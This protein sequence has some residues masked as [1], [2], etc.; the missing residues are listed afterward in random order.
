[1]WKLWIWMCTNRDIIVELTRNR[2]IHT[3]NENRRK[4]LKSNEQQQ[5]QQKTST[6]ISENNSLL[7][8]HL[9]IRNAE[10]RHMVEAVYVSFIWNHPS[11]GNDY[12]SCGTHNQL[13]IINCERVSLSLVCVCVFLNGWLSQS[14]PQPNNLQLN[15]S[16]ANCQQQH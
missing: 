5:K 4:K 13:T 16:N 7:R 9:K 14:H 1:M 3:L 8:L 6:S 12:T 10:V 2:N 15:E 11:N